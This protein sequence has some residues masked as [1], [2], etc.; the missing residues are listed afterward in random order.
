ML[1]Q[2]RNSLLWYFSACPSQINECPHCFLSHFT[3]LRLLAR[4]HWCN[5]ARDILPSLNNNV[6]KWNSQPM[7]FMRLFPCMNICA[8]PTLP[9]VV[10][11][12]ETET[13]DCKEENYPERIFKLVSYLLREY[14]VFIESWPSF[15]VCHELNSCVYCLNRSYLEYEFKVLG[16]VIL[17]HGWII[18]CEGWDMFLH[19]RQHLIWQTSKCL[20]NLVV[21]ELC[22][23]GYA[24]AHF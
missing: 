21:S 17:N 7:E 11:A 3:R 4:F 23:H 16:V 13:L 24:L 9:M 20:S 14:A 12:Y 19:T 10:L 6:A 2:L 15:A 22:W 1:C 18:L 5:V 8:Q